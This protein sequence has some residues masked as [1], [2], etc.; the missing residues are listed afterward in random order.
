MGMMRRSFTF[1]AGTLFGLYIAQ[2]YSVPNVS[3]LFNYGFVMAKH[4]EET[5]RKPN[6]VKTKN[7]DLH[8]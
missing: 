1:V 4:L 6:V 2:N 7:G 5:Y 3:K 8:E